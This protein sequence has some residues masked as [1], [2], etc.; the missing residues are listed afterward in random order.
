MEDKDGGWGTLG[1][2]Y[3]LASRHVAWIKV[4]ATQQSNAASTWAVS[5]LGFIDSHDAAPSSRL[6]RIRFIIRSNGSSCSSRSIV[7][8]KRFENRRPKWAADGRGG[9]VTNTE[10]REESFSVTVTKNDTSS[11]NCPPNS[12][13]QLDE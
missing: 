5:A 9:G 2:A 8:E 10:V 12:P 4:I 13:R 7:C 11:S 6:T 1:K 3:C